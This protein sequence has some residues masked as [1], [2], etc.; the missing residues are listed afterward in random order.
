MQAELAIT[1]E[2]IRYYSSVSMLYLLTL[3][4]AVLAFKPIS[5]SISTA[6]IAST[7]PVE[8]S[9]EQPSKQII[10]GKPTRITISSLGID[11]PIDEG[12]YNP[13]DGS[14]SLSGYHAQYAMT[15]P[16]AN[17]DNGNTFIYGHNNKYVF[18]PLKNITPG[19]QAKVYTDNNKVFNYIFD[20]TYAVAPDNTSVLNYQG[21]AILTV[22]TCSGAWNEQRQMYVFKFSNIENQL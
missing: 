10:T 18:G 11:L 19:A 12:R 5:H 2:K 6:A 8:V 1:I 14:W 3:L 15:T 13:S 22:Q 7:L 21:P 4:F 9:A 20:S 17:D 16:L